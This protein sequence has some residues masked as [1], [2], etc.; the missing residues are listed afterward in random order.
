MNPLTLVRVATAAALII[1]H[2]LLFPSQQ[3]CT[4]VSEPLRIR[5]RT[6][7]FCT[8]GCWRCALCG[9]SCSGRGCPLLCVC[10]FLVCYATIHAILGA[11]NCRCRVQHLIIAS[12]ASLYIYEMYTY[13]S[14]FMA[15]EMSGA[16]QTLRHPEQCDK[17]LSKVSLS[18]SLF[19]ANRE[20]GLS[21]SINVAPRKIALTK[22]KTK[23]SNREWHAK[24]TCV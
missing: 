13:H 5:A 7:G 24:A 6:G 11:C 21:V 15:W 8:N 22:N 10:E 16:R 3:N 23:R 12:P 2:W 4:F 1:I 14:G 19:Y 9:R 17:F 18:V 20:V